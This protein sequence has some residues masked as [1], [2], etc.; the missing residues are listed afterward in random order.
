[1]EEQRNNS[2]VLFKN[3]NKKSEKSPDY[4]GEAK[5]N[6]DDFKLAAWIKDG[7]KGKFM[8]LFIQPKESQENEGQ[9]QESV[10]AEDDIPF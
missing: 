10:I 9:V 4:W 3:W 5:V 8:S 1:M 7:R 2:G 6:G